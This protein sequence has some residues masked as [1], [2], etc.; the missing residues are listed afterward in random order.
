MDRLFGWSD[1]EYHPISAKD[2]S[3]LHQFGPELEQMD[4]SEIF[5]KRFNAKGSVNAYVW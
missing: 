3:Q 5:T 4:G 1:V 2:L